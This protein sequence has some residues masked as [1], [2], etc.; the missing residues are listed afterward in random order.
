[1]DADLEI[2]LRGLRCPLPVL[3]VKKALGELPA[4][5]VLR[6]FADDPGA[7]EDIPAFIKQS[8]HALREVIAADGG[9]YFV[10]VKQ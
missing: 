9:R 7:A 8:G 10:V 3:R 6:A 1:M 5:G 4:G 2:D